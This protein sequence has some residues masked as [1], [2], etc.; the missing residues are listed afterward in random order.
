LESPA[1]LVTLGSRPSLTDLT[2]DRAFVRAAAAHFF[3][4]SLSI[5]FGF[6]TLECTVDG[7]AV[8]DVYASDVFLHKEN[9]LGPVGAGTLGAISE[10]VKPAFLGK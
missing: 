10:Q 5:E 9:P 4:D 8:L 3:K 2:I 6:Q 7:L 1:N